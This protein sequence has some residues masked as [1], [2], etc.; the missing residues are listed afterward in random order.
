MAEP[1]ANEAITGS[2][3]VADLEVGPPDD[4][5][6]IASAQN[7]HSSQG[8][9]ASS[10]QAV[11]ANAVAKNSSTS[12]NAD[13]QDSNASVPTPPPREAAVT[14]EPPQTA[15][16]S[17]QPFQTPNAPSQIDGLDGAMSSDNATYGTRSRNRTGNARPN[18]AE[19]QDMDFE[20]SSAANASKKKPAND[21]V[22]SGSQSSAEVK[23]VQEIARMLAAGNSAPANANGVS[24]KESTP[25]TPGVAHT[26]KKRKAAGAPTTIT[27]T[28]PVSDSPAPTAAR[29]FAA[30]ST[31]ARETN[32]L[33]F[34]KH[35]SCLNKKGELLADDGTK[36]CVNGKPISPESSSF[37]RSKPT[38]LRP[39]HKVLRLIFAI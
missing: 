21:P 9:T 2:S 39:T 15:Q 12:V 33:T 37:W 22:A 31:M 7:S 20:L 38:P 28:P 27:Q 16:V 23:R 34:T 30:P 14:Q 17:S 35:R 5:L 19:D 8:M 10:F 29:K 26:S 36:L 4:P 13:A 25:G 3:Q 32:V 18:Y 24:A 11:N 1:T 6:Q